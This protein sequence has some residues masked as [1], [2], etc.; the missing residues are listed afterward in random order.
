MLDPSGYELEVPKERTLR[1]LNVAD[2]LAPIFYKMRW[3]L[4]AAAHGYFITSD[5][6][7]V[8]IIGRRPHDRIDRNQGFLDKRA[9]VSFPLSPKLLLLLSWDE[10]ALERGIVDRKPLTELNRIRAAYCERYLYAHVRDRRLEKLAAEFKDSRA[11]I[12]SSPGFGPKKFA[13]VT[14]VRRSRLKETAQ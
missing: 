3:S 10:A 7:L 2:T 9:E 8:R 1:V 5:N 14:V 13:T 12:M 11:G 4:I 6:P